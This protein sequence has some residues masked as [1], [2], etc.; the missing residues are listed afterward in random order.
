MFTSSSYTKWIIFVFQSH[1]MQ[2]VIDA[3]VI[4]GRE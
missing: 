2:S 3:K 1:Q 4:D